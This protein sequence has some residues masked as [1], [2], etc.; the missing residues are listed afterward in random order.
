MPHVYDRFIKAWGMFLL[1]DEVPLYSRTHLY[2]HFVLHMSLYFTN[3]GS[4]F[5]G[6]SR[7]DNFDNPKVCR[8][9][10]S[11]TPPIVRLVVWPSRSIFLPKDLVDSF[12]LGVV[13]R[14]VMT[15]IM[16]TTLRNVS[17]ALFGKRSR[18]LPILACANV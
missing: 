5:Y 3:I 14:D 1:Y 11:T 13:V 7:G 12:K 17:V 18:S 9:L 15:E 2:V 10:I 6:L 16:G 4:T 8:D